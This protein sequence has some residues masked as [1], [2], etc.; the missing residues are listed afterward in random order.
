MY[1]DQALQAA[2]KLYGRVDHWVVHHV[3][4]GSGTVQQMMMMMML[5][6]ILRAAQRW[7]LLSVHC[8]TSFL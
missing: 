6:T 4:G 3:K 5:I 7:R 1:R 2:P 8:I